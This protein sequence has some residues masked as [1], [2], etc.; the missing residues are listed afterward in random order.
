MTRAL[1][2]TVAA[3]ALAG[4]VSL[5]RSETVAA[6]PP[7]LTANARVTEIVLTRMPDLKVT[8]GFDDLFR[9]RVQAKLDAC[10]TGQRPLRLDAV[11]TRFDKANPVLTAVVAGSNVLRGSARLVDVETGQT[12]G[13]YK[14]GKTVVGGRFAVVVMAEAEEQLSDAFGEEL[15]K[16]AF[17]RDK[18][19]P[20]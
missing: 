11:I 8:P 2:A 3:L 19:A 20:G 12:V 9:Q 13:D 18:Q 7:E 6:L 4:C 17:K 16:Q 10:A 14:V 5:S 15:C 1:L